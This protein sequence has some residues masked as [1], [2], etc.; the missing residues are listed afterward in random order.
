MIHVPENLRFA[1]KGVMAVEGGLREGGGIKGTLFWNREV[2]FDE[3][4][5]VVCV[6]IINFL[7]C[8]KILPI[9]LGIYAMEN[10]LAQ[11]QGAASCRRRE[12]DITKTGDLTERNGGEIGPTRSAV[13]RHADN[14]VS[15]LVGPSSGLA[16]WQTCYVVEIGT[17]HDPEPI[18]SAGHDRATRYIDICAL[19]KKNGQHVEAVASI[20]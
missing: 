4:S 9:T 10:I 19:I 18:F 2:A 7:F 1:I 5:A 20:I 6:D 17:T 16:I 3:L 15:Q 12:M 11:K 13:R 8:L 14:K